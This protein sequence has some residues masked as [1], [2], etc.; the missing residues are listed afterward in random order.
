MI[1]GAANGRTLLTDEVIEKLLEFIRD[2]GLGIGD[3]L[4]TEAELTGMFGVSRIVIRESIKALSFL[5]L[6]DTRPRRG[7][8]VGALD[9]ERLGRCLSFQ[10]GITRY[11]RQAILEARRT[12]EVSHL[13]LVAEHLTAGGIE[14]L[15]AEVL[16]CETCARNADF[17]GFSAHDE[18]LHEIL[19]EIGGNPILLT[20]CTLLK[21]YFTAQGAHDDFT[22]EDMLDAAR[23]HRQVVEALRDHNI[24]LAKGT[25]LKHLAHA[26]KHAKTGAQPIGQPPTQKNTAEEPQ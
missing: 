17:D 26:A 25:L 7:T 15:M 22:R 14:S 12:I 9:V 5:G 18:R 2:R 11:P 4:P 10:M 3:R 13:E 6:L 16:A 19:L 8:V 24:R 21:Q 1:A 23:E 20:F